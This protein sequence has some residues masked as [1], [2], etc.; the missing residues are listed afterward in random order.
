MRQWLTAGVIGL[1]AVAFLI[2][3]MVPA[4]SLTATASTVTDDGMRSQSEIVAAKQEFFDRVWHE[5]HLVVEGIWESGE[6]PR[7][8]RTSTGGARSRRE[9]S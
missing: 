7:P 9:H 5:R 8:L 2:V 3:A 4:V 1:F 6:A